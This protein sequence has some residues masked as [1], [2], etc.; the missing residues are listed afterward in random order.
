MPPP[1]VAVILLQPPDDELQVEPADPIPLADADDSTIRTDP[2][3]YGIYCT[4]HGNHATH[5]PDDLV[6]LVS[7]SDASTFGR[8]RE[9]T[10]ARPWW[11]G[12]GSSLQAVKVNY[13]TPFLN[14]TMFLLMCWFYSGSNMKSLAELDHLINEVIL[15]KE[16]DRADLHS[17]CAAK[18][19]EHLDNYHGDPDNICSSFSTSDGWQEM[20]MKICV[21]ADG[22]TH[23]SLEDTPEFSVPGLFYHRPLEVIKNAFHEALAEHVH[24]TPFEQHYLP[25]PDGPPEHIYSEIYTSPVM[26]E[27]HDHICSQPREDGC[28]LE[29]VV[30]AIMLWSDST[31]LAS[32]GTM[33]LWLIYLFLG[34]Q[35]KYIRGKTSAFAAHHIAYIPKLSDTIQDFY[36]NTFGKA[37]TAQVLMHCRHE[38]MQAIWLLLMDN[39]FMHAYEF[40]IVL[41]CLDGIRRCIFPCFFTYSAD[42]PENNNTSGMKRLAGRD[43]EDLL[44]CAIP[45]F[46]GLLPSPYNESLFDL[47]FELATWHGLAKLQMHTDMTL[48]FLDSSTTRLGQF[49]RSFMKATAKEYVMKDLPSKEAARGHRKANKAAKGTRSSTDQ[50]PRRSG[51]QMSGPKGEC[52][53][54]Q[55]KRFYPHVSKA[56]FTAGIAKQQCRERLLF[57]M[58]EGSPYKMKGKGKQDAGKEKSKVLW[59]SSPDAPALRFKDSEPLPYSDPE[60]HYHISTSTRYHIN[61]Y[62]WLVQHESDPALNNFLPQLKDHLLSHL[63]IILVHEKIFRHKAL[64]VNYTTYDLRHNQDSLNPRTNA[65]IMLLAHE[66]GGDSHPYWCA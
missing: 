37:A 63:T 60:H 45:V 3:H 42:Y 13:F 35:S 49:L 31:Y 66:D 46:E 21:P 7:I 24:F 33:S 51:Q 44:Q 65:D 6:S 64:R 34:N 10:S 11:S 2:N 14:I 59:L 56:K 17:F 27:E 38:L 48:N 16:F 36:C 39:D 29:T 50:G 47:L 18:E 1:L 57:K 28:T 52:E 41:E 26:L 61:I 53:H 30:A 54:Q 55:V 25:S 5:S 20:S 40:G 8:Q 12:F 4:Y 43:F 62:K 32:F 9:L 15:V 23:E 19:V 22:V 58:A